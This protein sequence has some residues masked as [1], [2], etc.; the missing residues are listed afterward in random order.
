MQIFP[1]RFSRGGKIEILKIAWPL[2]LSTASYSIM[3]FFDRMMLTRY[4]DTTAAAATGAGILAFALISLFLGISG[5]TTTFVSQYYG[6]GNKKMCVISFWHGVYFA[7]LC[8]ILYPFLMRPLGLLIFDFMKH[9]PDILN[10]EKIYFGTLAFG[11]IFPLA[12]NS[13]SAFFSGRGKTQ[14]VMWV[15]MSIACIN[16]F[17][18]YCLIFGNF[19]APELGI[20][21]AAIATVFSSFCGMIF[22]FILISR[23][24][25]RDEFHIFKLL[26]LKFNTLKNLI[27]YGGPSGV[28][29]SLDIMAFSIFVLI[30]GHIG[31]VQLIASNIALTINTLSF[32]PMLGFSMATTILVG[33]YIGMNDKKTAEK[34]AYSG[35]KCAAAYM[36]FMGLLFI[37]FPQIFFNFFKGKGINQEMFNQI[38]GYGKWLLVMLAF[39]GVFDAINVT[40]SGALKGAGDTWFTMWISVLASWLVFMPAVYLATDFFKLGIFAA[41]TCFVGYVALLAALYWIRFSA[42]KWKLIDIKEK[43]EPPQPPISEIT[44]EAAIF[45]N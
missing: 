18:N 37:L 25:I 45:E 33:K 13:L 6:A 28:S 42:G 8:G 34:A 19:G 44:A 23:K 14:V 38:F 17:L 9:E 21:G 41:W 43:P 24:K 7:L 31:R 35:V 11:A 22:Y 32:L 3:H 2:I 1:K 36:I 26:A 4:S 5:Y 39:L 16:I 15:T 12:N 40:F 10:A 30:I 20:K 27:K 29:F